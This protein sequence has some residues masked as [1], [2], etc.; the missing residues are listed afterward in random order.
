[1][2]PEGII[3]TKRAGD[4]LRTR[5]TYPRVHVL[6]IVAVRPAVEATV[7]DRGHVIGNEVAAEFITLVDGGPQGT[8]RRLPRQAHRI[9]QAGGID[10]MRAALRVDFPNRGSPFFLVDAV[11]GDVAV[12]AH[13]DVQ[14]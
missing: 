11:F 5:R 2:R 4:K 8:R 7:A 13:G 9:A 3:G 12:G 6:A 10:T 1:M 14:L